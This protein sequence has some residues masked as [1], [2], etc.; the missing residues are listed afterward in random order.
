MRNTQ[1]VK[2]FIDK[3]RNIGSP[4]KDVIYDY[5][6]ICKNLLYEEEDAVVETIKI[7]RKNISMWA[8]KH[9]NIYK[10]KSPIPYFEKQDLDIKSD[11]FVGMPANEVQLMTS[12]GSTTGLN[13]AYLRWEPLLHFIEC[14]NHYDMI[15]D[16]FDISSNPQILFMFGAIQGKGTKII[17]KLDDSKN[18]TEHHGIKRKAMVHYANVD[19]LRDNGRLFFKYLF[20]YIKENPIDVMLTPGSSVRSLCS[21][22]KK[23]GFEG[24]ICKLLSNTNEF[25]LSE[26]KNFL[27]TNKIV[28][29][30]CDHMRCWDG[31]ASFFDCKHGTSHLMDNMSWSVEK[32]KKLIATDYFSLPSPFV[33][34]WNGDKCEI[35][36]KYERCQCGRIYR[37]FKFL[38]NRPFAVKGNSIK[39]YREKIAACKIN[40]IKQIRCELNFFIVSS[41]RKLSDTEKDRVKTVFTGHEVRFLVE[42]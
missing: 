13:F 24:K 10:K 6:P 40:G 2:D 19:I 9:S 23:E 16:E 32:E 5:M 29:H 42:A 27:L 1:A 15:L 17:T 21:A 3:W 11:W 38:E 14:E 25:M 28:D 34:F 35:K 26:D 18:F 7:L 36:N 20:N 4:C 12:S 41:T 30:I 8:A 22:I 33:N 37:P 39:E 31:G